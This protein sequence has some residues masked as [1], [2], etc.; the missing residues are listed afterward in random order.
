MK[1]RVNQQNLVG[2]LT[3][4]NLL[5]SG[6]QLALA[7]NINLKENNVMLK[8]IMLNDSIDLTKIFSQPRLDKSQ[9]KQIKPSIES[10]DLIRLELVGTL[11][12]GEQSSAW[13]KVGQQV[14]QL[15]Q[16]Q[17]IPGSKIRITQIRPESVVINTSKTCNSSVQCHSTINI[18]DTLF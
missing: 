8:S 3:V 14:Y 12:M 15:R 16:G 6:A 4:L 9:F 11:V 13:V 7:E 2:L 18:R 5:S 10:P 17:T 1:H